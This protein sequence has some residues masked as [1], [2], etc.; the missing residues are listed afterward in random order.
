[1]HSSKKIQNFYLTALFCNKTTSYV[2]LFFILWFV[3]SFTYLLCNHLPI[4]TVLLF[5][6]TY[7]LI[8]HYSVTQPT[9]TSSLSVSS[10]E[11]PYLDSFQS[12]KINS[13]VFL[14]YC[15]WCVTS[16]PILSSLV[17]V[18]SYFRVSPV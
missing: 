18:F 12:F 11:N 10:E 2:V 16:F 9:T 6:S 15:Y 8:F 14:S 1:M 7:Y 17:C 13:P 4:L 3:Y 5:I